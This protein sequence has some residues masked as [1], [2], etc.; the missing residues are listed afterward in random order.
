M[1]MKSIFEQN[2]GTY[3]QVGD[4]LIPD[5]SLPDAPA[6]PIGKYDRMRKRI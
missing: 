4:Y 1:K 5:I 6:Y 2:G 3:T